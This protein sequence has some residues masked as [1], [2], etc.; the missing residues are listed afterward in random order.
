MGAR[1]RSMQLL[2]SLVRIKREFASVLTAILATLVGGT[3]LLFDLHEPLGVAGGV[4]YLTLVLIGLITRRPMTILILAVVASALTAVGYFLS[5][6][7]GPP[8]VVLLNRYLALFA[9]W[10][11][12]MVL[13]LLR[14]L[15][16]RDALTGVFTRAY[17]LDETARHIALWRRWGTPLSILILDLDQFKV[18]NDT[19]GH[20]AGDR[21][22]AA[23][24]HEL[25]RH[26]RGSECVARV[27][28]E[29]FAI[30]LPHTGATGAE[31]LG[32]RLRHAI[33]EL[34]IEWQGKRL[35]ITASFGAAELRSQD[36]DAKDLLRAADEAM[37]RAKGEGRNRVAVAED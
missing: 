5:P 29:E 15:I 18:I 23:V 31:L 9:I 20:P 12:A 4:P 3:A 14:P 25:T 17:L 16:V 27:G 13:L 26:V 24:A 7:G 19:Y 35:P 21:V 34:V 10:A 6:P 8:Y 33:E 32:T 22:L 1:G 37:Y 2:D 28:G 36:W 11:T 30:L